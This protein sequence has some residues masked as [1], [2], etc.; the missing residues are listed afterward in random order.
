VVIILRADDLPPEVFLVPPLAGGNTR[1]A[2]PDEFDMD[3]F[4]DYIED[5][6]LLLGC[7]NCRSFNV[8]EAKFGGR[9][10]LFCNDCNQ[11][12][13]IPPVN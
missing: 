9:R 5:M 11:W 6:S 1:F 12:V 3:A 13:E 8:K 4:L 7:P 2:R 10:V